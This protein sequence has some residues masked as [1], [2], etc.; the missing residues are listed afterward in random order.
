TVELAPAQRQ[1]EV[2]AAATLAAAIG[3]ALATAG[4][5]ALV[6]AH[7]DHLTGS[8]FAVVVAGGALLGLVG[9]A[10]AHRVGSS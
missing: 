5:G 2:N 10:A 1:G 8:P 7:A 4:G 6:A 9:A 3:T